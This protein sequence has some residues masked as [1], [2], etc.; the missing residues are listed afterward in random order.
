MTPQLTRRL[1]HGQFFGS[2]G[3]RAEAHG[4]AIALM[5]PDPEVEV[6]LHTHDTAHFILHLQ[7]TY[8][9]SA[10][11]APARMKGPAL[12][13]NP[14]GT[15]HR[16][17]YERAGRVFAGQFLSVGV[18]PDVMAA[19]DPVEGSAVDARRVTSPRALGAISRILRE[20]RHW[21]SASPV[22][23][24]A[25]CLDLLGA[26]HE[27][28]AREWVDGARWVRRAREV[29]HDRCNE[30]VT[31]REVAAECG[32]HP[33]YLARVF[34]RHF[35]MSPAAYLRRCRLQRAAALLADGGEILSLV[36]LR[37]GFVDQSHLTKS[38]RKA[39]A[40]TPGEYR[41]LVRGRAPAS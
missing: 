22:V 24:E 34:R 20:C 7:G 38:F 19:L 14:S 40:M 3:H 32:V 9:T 16:D 11:G 2:A 27:R 5:R 15:T 41:I 8:L 26:V 18:A 36:A 12:F 4:F 10:S 17:R 6:A 37:C 23:A 30:A 21:S 28:D 39:Y 29:L 25:L 35:H 31:V 33:V 13:Y 1:G